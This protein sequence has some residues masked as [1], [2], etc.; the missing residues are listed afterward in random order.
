MGLLEHIAA[1]PATGS[2]EAAGWRWLGAVVRDTRR[3]DQN[4]AHLVA[5]FVAMTHAPT[6]DDTRRL[7]VDRLT[8]PDPNLDRLMRLLRRY[9]TGNQLRALSNFE[10]ELGAR[11]V[12]LELEQLAQA[13]TAG[14][15]PMGTVIERLRGLCQAQWLE[16]DR[17]LAESRVFGLGGRP[18][19]DP[20]AAYDRK[21]RRDPAPLEEEEVPHG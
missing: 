11:R 4:E 17:G 1:S 13:G 6:L 2:D 3:A 18:L 14:D 8:P 15:D 5:S 20:A 10:K 19:E 12:A 7:P 21:L 16:R 9:P